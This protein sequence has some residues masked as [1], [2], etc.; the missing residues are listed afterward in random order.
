MNKRLAEY[1]GRPVTSPFYQDAKPAPVK[2]T[3]APV[4]HDLAIVKRDRDLAECALAACRHD[5][6]AERAEHEK[7]RTHLDSARTAVADLSR[8]V[9]RITAERDAALANLASATRAVLATA[10]RR[11][12]KVATAVEPQPGTCADRDLAWARSLPEG[13]PRKAGMVK[14]I[15]RSAR[16]EH[17]GAEFNAAHPCVAWGSTP[18]TVELNT[19]AASYRAMV[20]CAF[21]PAFPAVGESGPS[22][23]P[24]T[25]PPAS[26]WRS[27]VASP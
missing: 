13:D 14:A 6:D 16:T 7:T 10:P 2:R 22:Y 24:D 1:L 4:D 26:Y 15:L 9:E 5:L 8:E 21:G 12:R 19:V 27:L 18:E 3:R 11:P 17:E 23:L 25:L 20:E